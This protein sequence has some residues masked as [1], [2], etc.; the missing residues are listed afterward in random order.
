MFSRSL[1]LVVVSVLESQASITVQLP[2]ASRRV[3][4]LPPINRLSTE[5]AGHYS[6]G[7]A[8]VE[9]G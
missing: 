1:N 2:S 7:E 8:G 4:Q 3:I 5:K 6:D 9:V